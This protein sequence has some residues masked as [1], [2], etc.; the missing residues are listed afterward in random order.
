VY[1]VPNHGESQEMLNKVEYNLRIV[2]VHRGKVDL[3]TKVVNLQRN[4]AAGIVIIDDGQCNDN[5]TFCGARA[6]S[7]TEGGFAPMDEEMAWKKITIPVC[8]ITQS[9]GSK[10]INL[11]DVNRVFI[12]QFGYQNVTPEVPAYGDYDGDL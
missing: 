8:L 12:P 3:Q 7:V 5:F 2:L 10:L 6:G 11:L 4:G 9:S 1:A